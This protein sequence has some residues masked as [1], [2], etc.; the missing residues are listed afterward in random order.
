MSV[1]SNI[2]ITTMMLKTLV[3][4]LMTYCN[5]DDINCD[6]YADCDSDGYKLISTT[7]IVTVSVDYN[8]YADCDSD[9]YKL[10]STT[11][12]VTVSVDYKIR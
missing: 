3:E 11:T 6:K 12:K 9:G 10:I 7:T 8:M 5:D 4:L 2:I 1:I